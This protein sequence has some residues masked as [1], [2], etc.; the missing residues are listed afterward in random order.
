[1]LGIALV[2][3]VLAAGG[4]VAHADTR[5]SGIAAVEAPPALLPAGKTYTVTLLTGDVVTVHT[6][7]SGC[8]VVSVKPARPSG[9]L[10]RSCGPDGRVRVVPG[11]VAHL[12]GEVY[13]EALFDVTT[14]ITEGYDD[15]RAKELPLIVRPGTARAASTFAAGL[16][17]RR[18]LPSIGAV[19]G[20]Q[21]KGQV[22]EPL[23]GGKIWLDHKVKATSLGAATIDRNLTQVSAPQAWASGYTGKGTRV[24]VLDTGVDATHPDLARKVAEKKDFTV[25]G[26][27]AVDGHG[28][29]THVAATIAGSGAAARGERRGVAPG[30][31]LLAGKVLDDEGYGTDSQ[32]IAGM[33]W[34]APR[35]DVVNLSLGGWD[36]S[37]GT[38]PMSRALDA[39]SEEHGTLFVVAAGNDGPYDRIITAPA[40][41]ASALTVGAVDG[42]DRLAEFSSRGPL[43]N[44]AAAKPELVAPG[45][46]IVAARAAGTTMG[47]A[48]DARYT[49]ASGTSM[50]S[51]H[52][53]GAAALLAQ[54]HPDWSPGRLKAALVG[55]AD[56]VAGADPYTVGAGRLNAARALGGVV[57]DVGLVNLGAEASEA[58]LTWTNTGRRAARVPLAV[59][60]ADRHGGTS[61]SATLSESRL[62]IAP[63][64]SGVAVLRVDRA[65]LAPGFYGATV[66]AGG[67]GT[68]LVAFEVKPPTHELAVSLTLPADAPADVEASANAWIIN[69]DDPAAFAEIH[70]VEKGE[71]LRVP[72]PAGRYSV[73]GSIWEGDPFVDGRM[74]LVGDPDVTVAGDTAV[75]MDGARA[76]PVKVAVD[77]VETTPE[78]LGISFEQFGRRGFGWSDFAYAWGEQATRDSV[79]AAPM[80]EPGLGTFSAY[81]MAGLTAK[82]SF[83]DLIKEHERGIPADPSYTA[84]AAEQARLVRIDQRFHR[85]D[86]PESVTSHKRYGVSEAGGLISE[87]YTD[88][89]YGDRTDYLS[90]G[91]AWIDEA[92]YDG[93]VTQEAV[94]RYEPGSRHEKEWVR[95][96]L[97]PDWYDDPTPA[98]SGCTPNPVS[99]TRGNLHVEIVPMTDQHQRFTC[100]EQGTA[101]M[102]LHKDGAKVGEVAG[103]F[104]DF[105][106]PAGAGT[107]RL[108]HEVDNSGWLPVSTRV[109]TAWTFRSTGPSGTGSARVP[110][111]SVDYTLPLDVDNKPAGD[112]AAFTVHQS[113]GVDRQ[114]VTSFAFWT[115]VDGGATWQSVPVVRGE[116]DR[117][118]AKVPVG[119]AVSLRVRAAAS[120]GSVIDQTI[121][122]AYH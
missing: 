18:N 121:I 107:Y 36:P 35:A 32:V 24:A 113:H 79:Y 27:G 8:P 45:V 19:A 84:T 66:T 75:V 112:T 80:D 31:T 53:A 61:R 38:D 101:S 96:P 7:E 77:G 122:N 62:S 17:G 59:T 64:G 3:G 120:A 104:G 99:R 11:D 103:S 25:E 34:A 13:D 44:T 41:A 110:L 60:V 82:G 21:P 93:L 28:H 33:E 42:G 9:V 22:V 78:A 4:G 83:Y 40:A 114:E 58:K 100:F 106:I 49:A 14:L 56:P 55:A 105:A 81:T 23:G 52:V 109:S 116:G 67:A 108:T 92:F 88:Q 10:R 71:T 87:S 115:S 5:Q 12:L 76:V 86:S 48:V 46:D 117:Y 89:V 97:R 57:S 119:P 91:F 20:R 37:D 2:A 51:P 15:A 73:L 65:G 50:A 39:L 6:R 26:G 30:A 111:L 43:I 1:L 102:S 70:G 98:L 54:R 118:T 68:T 16:L 72:V 85:L 95:Q 47:R 69:L 63:G 74:I 29:G 94:R 90:P